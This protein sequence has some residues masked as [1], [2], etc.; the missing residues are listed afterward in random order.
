[1]AKK[2]ITKSKMAHSTKPEKQTGKPD[3]IKPDDKDY[4]IKFT[5]HT[6]IENFKN[7]QT[8][9]WPHPKPV[10]VTNKN[11]E[12]FMKAGVFLSAAQLLQRPKV[13]PETEKPLNGSGC[14]VAILDTGVYAEHNDLKGKVIKKM[15]YKGDTAGDVEDLHGH[16]THLAGIIAGTVRNPVIGGVAPGAK[17]VSVKVTEKKDDHTSWYKITDGLEQVLLH[18]AEAKDDEKVTAVMLSF[19]AFEN[20]TK[21]ICTCQHRLSK[22]IHK[23][24]DLDIP[25]IISAGNGFEYF[26]AEGLSYPAHINKVIACGATYNYRYGRK[27]IMDLTEFT[28]RIDNENRRFNNVF[29]LAPGKDTISCGI[30]SPDSYRRLS[31]SCQASAVITGVILLLQEKYKQRMRSLPSVKKLHSCITNN[32][33]VLE[34][35]S[36]PNTSPSYKKKFRHLNTN[37][38]LRNII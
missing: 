2:K 22:I 35:D 1:M 23:L 3:D 7:I 12:D 33:D 4:L 34:N 13:D 32:S 15:N 25:V 9:F 30:S 28:Q 17:I 10:A 37:R 6:E 5:Q 29:I 21:D 16:G 20:V 19:N 11:V 27:K 24:Y 8:A 31:G 18:N 26:N 38:S 36:D 14:I